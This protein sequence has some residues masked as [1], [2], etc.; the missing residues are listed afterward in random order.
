MSPLPSATSGNLGFASPLKRSLTFP[1]LVVYGLAYVAPITFFTTYGVATERSAGHLALSYLVATAGIFM[2]ALSY[3]HLASVYPQAGSVYAYASRAL[4]PTVGFFAGWAIALDYVLIPALN[5]IVIG[6]YAHALWPAIPAGGFGLLAVLGV[7][8]F[9]LR[10]IETTDRTARL[11]L[12]LELVV[13]GVFLAA[14]LRAPALPA[15]RPALALPALLGGAAL[16]ALSFLGFDAIT[17]LSE[18]ARQPTRDVPRAVVATCVLA[19]GLFIALAAVSFR[20]HPAV[21]FAS[22]DLAGFQLARGLGGDALST[23]V[24]IGQ[25]VGSLASALAGQ[26]GAARLL[27][28]MSRDGGLPVPGLARLHPVRRTPDHATRLLAMVSAFGLLL[29]LEQAVALVNFGALLG[30]F[31]VNLAVAGHFVVRGGRRDV[32]GLLAYGVLPLLG[33]VV[34]ALLFVGLETRAKL[35]GVA[36]LALGAL[37]LLRGARPAASSD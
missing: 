27:F 31:L 1:A 17:T 19:G 24:S 36:W 30:F 33:A 13:I 5:F 20:A 4:H 2:T 18:E 23:L 26:A 7:T 37:R 15:P 22:P 12:G 10:G 11:V 6:L 28:G 29:P 35:I 9:N 3:G 8:A 21:R 14:A 16:V 25:I 32:R 34:V